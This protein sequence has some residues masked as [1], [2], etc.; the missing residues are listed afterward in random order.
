MAAPT[1]V[2]NPVKAS[3]GI[4]L[5]EISP[6]IEM[7]ALLEVL[8]DPLA[9]VVTG[10]ATAVMEGLPEEADV[11]TPDGVVPGFLTSNGWDRA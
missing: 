11:V 4:A 6:L 8:F 7:G 2:M 5:R 1:R 9:A 3:T 10:G